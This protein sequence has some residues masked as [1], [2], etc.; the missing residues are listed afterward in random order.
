MNERELLDAVG[1]LPKSIEPPRDLWPGIEARLGAR[2]RLWYWIPLVAA[3]ALAAVLIGRGH[4][5]WKVTWLAGAGAGTLRVGEWLVTDD[6]SRALIAV[7]GIGQVEVRPDT[8]IRLVRAR[9]DDH[10]LALERGVIYAKVDT[11]PRLFY[12][13]TP[14]GT[15]IDLGCEYTLG[16]D[17]AGNGLLHVVRGIV[18]FQTGA[19]SAKVPMGTILTIRADEGPG[20]PYVEDASPALRRA[21][22]ALDVPAALRAARAED[23]L[24]LWHLLQRVAASGRGAVYD[25]LAVLVP[26]PPG[27]TRAAALAGDTASLDAYWKVIHRLHF[28]RV[29][30]SRP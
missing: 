25:R 14:A 5:G 19:L 20:I 8:R 2:S 7:G 18:E 16:T 11:V 21:L 26:P 30:L 4:E 28:R 27:V 6:S 12:V 13:E 23:A 1:R 29:I 9:A 22:A 17:S 10:R 3:A 15:A 24:S